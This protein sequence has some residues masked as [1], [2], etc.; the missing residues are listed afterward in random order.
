MTAFAAAVGAN[1]DLPPPTSV[2]GSYSMVVD[3]K[4]NCVWMSGQQ[5][6]MIVRFDPKTEE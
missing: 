5:A 1:D 4:N 6:D 2:I 3:K